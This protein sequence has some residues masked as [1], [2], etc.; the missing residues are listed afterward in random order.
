MCSRPFMPCLTHAGAFIV[1]RIGPGGRELCM[2]RARPIPRY[3]STKVQPSLPGEH[4]YE[5]TSPRPAGT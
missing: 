4:A 2:Y 5:T 1:Y 3:A